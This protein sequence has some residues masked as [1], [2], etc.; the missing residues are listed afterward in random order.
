MALN[1]VFEEGISESIP[2]FLE[3]EYWANIR[4]RRPTF[5]ITA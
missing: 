4:A 2:R 1:A 3:L 5:Q